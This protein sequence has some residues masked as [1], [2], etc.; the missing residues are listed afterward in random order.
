[1]ARRGGTQQPASGGP[2]RLR[3]P[4][5]ASGMSEI[6]GGFLAVKPKRNKASCKKK[7]KPLE[8]Q[9]DWELIIDLM[10]I[11]EEEMHLTPVE[12][13][14]HELVRSK[15][16]KNPETNLASDSWREDQTKNCGTEPHHEQH[17]QELKKPE[18]LNPR[19]IG[20]RPGRRGERF[21]HEQAKESKLLVKSPRSP[22][23]AS[24]SSGGR[25]L[26]VDAACKLK[27]ARGGCSCS[28]R[29]RHSTNLDSSAY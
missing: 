13:C 8:I 1:M 18:V 25:S 27:R 26:S 28:Y 12:Q 10:D 11:I 19:Q 4:R 6:A 17:N 5:T 3:L 22:T 9:K 24:C 16:T 20:T 23:Q 7:W 15:Q 29:P 21:L 14:L 2:A